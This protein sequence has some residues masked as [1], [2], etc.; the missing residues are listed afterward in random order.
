LAPTQFHSSLAEALAAAYEQC[1]E[2]S[3]PDADQLLIRLMMGKT[4]ALLAKLAS[5]SD[6]GRSC[7]DCLSML[8]FS[9]ISMHT[10]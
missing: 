7:N 3:T 5:L 2:Q 10:F 9:L 6:E 8:A 4:K 1:L